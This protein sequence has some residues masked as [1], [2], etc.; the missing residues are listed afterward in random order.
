[1]VGQIPEVN[2]LLVG[3]TEHSSVI[4]TAQALSEQG[5]QVE[6]VGVDGNGLVD[7]D[8]FLACLDASPSMVSV[9]LANN[10]TGV[11][12]SIAPLAAM[13][14]DAGGIMHTDAVQAAG[15]IGIDFAE[16]GAH[17]MTLSAHKIYGPKGVGALIVDKALKLSPLIHGGGQEKG[18][19]G[20]TENVPA[21]VGFGAAAMLAKRKL[22]SES[23]RLQGLRDRLQS[24]LRALGKIQ[25]F[26]ENAPRL[27]NTVFFSVPGIDGAALLLALDK[28]GFSVSSGSA[29]SSERLAPSHVLLAMGAEEEIAR[30]AI[31]VSLGQDNDAHDIDEFVEA[32]GRE[33]Q[34]TRR[35]IN[36]AAG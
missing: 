9:M 10:E 30:G 2:R 35:L 16:T 11:I 4:K 34:N 17:L 22:V 28:A 31:R 19:R 27:A 20:G 36:R 12:Q 33:I 25:I 13:V 32:L 24:G 8:H 5:W 29:C 14:R 7:Q 3:A 26:G 21:I 15:K 6:T 18:Y 1:G 23:I